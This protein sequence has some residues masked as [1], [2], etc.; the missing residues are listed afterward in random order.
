MSCYSAG[1]ERTCT[2]QHPGCT[3]KVKDRGAKQCVACAKF[4]RKFTAAPTVTGNSITETA[5]AREVTAVTDQHV[6]TLEDLIRVC[7]I[8]L[9]IWE[10]E[11]WVANKWEMGSVDLKKQTHVTPLFQ[12]KV[13]LKRKVLLLTIQSEISSLLADAKKAITQRKVRNVPTRPM[14]GLMLE[15]SI[16]DLHVGKLAWSGETGHQNYDVKIAVETFEL[17]LDTLL[18]RVSGY[19][20]DRIL[21]PVGNDLLNAD[22]NLNQTTGGTPQDTDSRFQKSF[23]TVRQMITTAIRRLRH[24][25]PVKVIMV[26]GNHDQLSVWHLGDSLE[27]FFHRYTDVVIDNLPTLRKYTQFGKVMLMHTHGNKGKPANYPLVMATEQPKMFGETTFREVHV[28]HVHKTKLDEFHGVRVR[29]SPA[30]C[31][32]DAWHSEN[33][34][35]GAGRSAEALVWHRTEGLIGTA[36]YTV[37]E[38]EAA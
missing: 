36:F 18:R 20:F 15:P 38:E 13:W 32:P 10:I 26:P 37:P 34:F 33:Q 3:G 29:T 27:C 9:T 35:V 21:F 19:K 31:P 30:L 22:S 24:L 12:I 14:T 1:K 5:N 4:A 17:A 11:R 6:R 16:P 8:D 25:A 23:S 28:G 2:A 7:D